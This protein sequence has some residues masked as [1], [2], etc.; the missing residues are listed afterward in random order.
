MQD[1]KVAG[2]T[3]AIASMQS[4]KPQISSRTVPSRQQAVKPSVVMSAQ[5]PGQSSQ[6]IRFE[7]ASTGMSQK[8]K[9]ESQSMNVRNTS[10]ERQAYTPISS[11]KQD[12]PS[13]SKTFVKP[14]HLQSMTSAKI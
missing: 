10:V 9:M 5:K 1:S 6:N 4:V 14:D 7:Q 2:F 11:L 3:T 8:F 13:F 12:K